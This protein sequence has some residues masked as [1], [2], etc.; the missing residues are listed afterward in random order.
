MAR[1]REFD[2][3]SYYLN[4]V[5][6]PDVDCE[7][8]EQAYRDSRGRSPRSLREDF[9]GAFANSCEW[10]KRG[11]DRRAI[12]I[13]L[14]PDPLGYGKAHYLTKLS[15]HQ[16]QRVHVINSSVLTVKAPR[17]DVTIALNFS[18]CL[19][20]S[21]LVLKRYFKR[22]YQG[23]KPDGVFVLDCFGGPECQKANEEVTK[24]GGFKYYWDQKN[25]DPVTNEAKFE[26][27]F[28]RKGEK[29]RLNQF[30]YDWRIWTIPEI[31]EV[32]QEVGFAK[33]HVYWEGTNRAGYGD[34]NFVRKTHG[35]PDCDAW[36]AYIVGEV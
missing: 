10:V 29:K 9:C 34:G 2:R 4:A 14:D 5:Q 12:A 32:M 16:A 8:I 13:D 15:A 1:L 33:T 24:V 35:E 7:F 17:V 31:R 19:F 36:V 21:R 6:S 27:H 26:M 28:K 3:Y 23:L 22:V 30:S 18:Y 11:R 20:K 25:Y